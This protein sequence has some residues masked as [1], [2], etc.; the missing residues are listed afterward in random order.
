MFKDFK[1]WLYINTSQ[2]FIYVGSLHFAL[3]PYW[4]FLG[5][6]NDY[7]W[8]IFLVREPNWLTFFDKLSKYQPKYRQFSALQKAVTKWPSSWAFRFFKAIRGT[9]STSVCPVIFQRVSKNQVSNITE[10][11]SFTNALVKIFKKILKKIFEN[12]PLKVCCEY[13]LKIQPKLKSQM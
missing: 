12:L 5:I 3:L 9:S 1:N 13:I 7:K 6:L 4:V 8:T 2:I 10:K 11:E